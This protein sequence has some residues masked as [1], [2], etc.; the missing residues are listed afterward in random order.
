MIGISKK[1]IG[2]HCKD[3]GEGS[4]KIQNVSIKD[5]LLVG[6]RVKPILQNKI[7]TASLTDK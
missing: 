5:V 7:W 4:T 6:G 2:L 3:R 1:K